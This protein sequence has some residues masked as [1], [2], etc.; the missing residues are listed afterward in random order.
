MKVISS[1]IA[2]GMIV[3]CYAKES[4]LSKYESS[5]NISISNIGVAPVKVEEKKFVRIETVDKSVSNVNS[6]PQ[7]QKFNNPN[8]KNQFSKDAST[9][10]SKGT[11]YIRGL[12]GGYTNYQ[13]DNR[14]ITSHPEGPISNMTYLTPFLYKGIELNKT[15][16]VKVN[17][18]GTNYVNFITYKP[19]DNV[20]KIQTLYVHDGKSSMYLNGVNTYKNDLFGTA[21]TFSLGKGKGKVGDYSQSGKNI[22]K[23]DG[24]SDLEQYHFTLN[25]EVYISDRD[26]LEFGG[27][28]DKGNDESVG[29][30]TKIGQGNSHWKNYGSDYLRYNLFA[31]YKHEF[32]KT[33]VGIKN[34]Y[35]RIKSYRHD[36]DNPRGSNDGRDDYYY[37]TTPY[38]TSFINDNWTNETGATVSRFKGSKNVLLRTTKKMT[39]FPT[40]EKGISPYTS[41]DY[42]SDLQ[43]VNFGLRWN[44]FKRQSTLSENTDKEW[45]YNL[46]YVYKLD[47]YNQLL[48]S[49]NHQLRRPNIKDYGSDGVTIGLGTLARP[50]AQGNPAIKSEKIDNYELGYKYENESTLFRTN[51]FYK[52]IKDFI[53]T[54]LYINGARYITTVGNAGRA[55]IR[56]VEFLAGYTFPTDTKVY[57]SFSWMKGEV[58]TQFGK[59]NAPNVPDYSYNIGIEQEIK[60]IKTEFGINYSVTAPV[61][62]STVA[63]NGSATYIDTKSVNDLSFYVRHEVFKNFFITG[64]VNNILDQDT[65]RI[66]T[67]IVNGARTVDG[68]SYTRSNR[69]YTLG[70][71]YHY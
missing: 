12:G 10:I 41:F 35:N 33:T 55:K 65:D 51:L 16:T 9:N 5:G 56:G 48:A 8:I 19:E 36:D 38:V 24:V 66:S 57:G 15:P 64:S 14:V 18:V 52:D 1:I 4:D 60:P 3:N 49:Y 17:G 68:Y 70:F 31:N 46:N 32:D 62:Y 59:L 7:V 20:N 53:A 42:D 58:K 61:R 25:N 29:Y 11:L 27:Y 23:T 6:L 47:Q 13:I 44:E 2:V 40:T 34:S 71:E 54:S 21:V 26:L 45:T 39:Y 67:S 50:D 63:V 43:A 37:E 22:T 28:L 69:S 30:V